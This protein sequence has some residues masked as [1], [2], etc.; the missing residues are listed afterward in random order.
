MDFVT[1]TSATS[2]YQQT[3]RAGAATGDKAYTEHDEDGQQ[4]EEFDGTSHKK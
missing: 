1:I 2:M 4:R 3:A